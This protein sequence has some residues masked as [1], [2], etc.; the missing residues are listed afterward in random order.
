M[1]G[2]R[3]ADVVC[4]EKNG[5]MSIRWHDGDHPCVAVLAESIVRSMYGIAAGYPE[6]VRIIEED[7]HADFQP[8]AFRA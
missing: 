6:M 2:L 8:S 4:D 3:N 7:H 5:M 1:I